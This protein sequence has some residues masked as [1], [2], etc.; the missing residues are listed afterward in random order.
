MQTDVAAEPALVEL[1]RSAS[2]LRWSDVP[3]DART[4]SARVL[5][6]TVGAMLAGGE[7]PEIVN[8]VHA[9][10]SVSRTSAQR[11]TVFVAGL[12]SAEPGEAAFVNGTAGTCLELDEACPPF[13]HPAIHVLPAALATAESLRRSGSG[14]LAAF[15][16]GYEVVVRLFDAYRL[17]YPVHPHGHLGAVGAAVAV[18]MLRRVDVVQPSLIAASLPILATWDPCLDG[19]TVRNTWA[20]IAGETGIRANRLA[21]AGFTGSETAEDT[22]FGNWSARSPSQ[23]P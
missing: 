5:A 3:A 11:A 22:A 8:L 18:A 23:M 21:A 6:D 14:L 12:P 20:G 15:V 10:A 4:H 17:P 1:V 13:S 2:W 9:G 16:A 19:A 7:R